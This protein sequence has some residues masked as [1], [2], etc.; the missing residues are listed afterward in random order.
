ML[1]LPTDRQRNAA[2]P[3]VRAEEPVH[4]SPEL[5][6]AVESLSR[7]AGTSVFIV[8]LAAFKALLC[9]YTGQEDIV[10]GT[11]AAD[12]SA[13]GNEL[14]L[15]QSADA[16]TIN[17]A[18]PSAMS[19]Q[20]LIDRVRRTT[21]DAFA[22]E[23]EPTLSEPAP[24]LGA[25]NATPLSV[26]F[27]FHADQ[28]T[29][30]KANSEVDAKWDLALSLRRSAPGLSGSLEYD[31]AL[32]DR[33]TVRRLVNHY[34]TL[35]EGATARPEERLSDLPLLGDAERRAVIDQSSG[36][37]SD[38]PR[39]KCVHELIQEQARRTPD[40]VAASSDQQLSYAELDRRSNKV[41]AYLRDLEIGPGS[42]V[43]ICFRHSAEELVA[44][45]GVLK[46]G[47]GYVPVDPDHPFFRRTFVLTDA[48]VKLVLTE[49]MLAGELVASGFQVVSLDA[50][51]SLIA[52]KDDAPVDAP[53]CAQDIAYVIYT[54]GSTGEPKGVAIAHQALVN[55]ISWANR[56]YLMGESAGFPLYS[57]GAFD[58]TVTSIYTPLI[59]G[60]TVVA[61]PEQRGKE[62][63]LSQI[64]AEP[65]VG[66]LKLTPSHLLLL[67]ELNNWKSAVKL[68]IVGGEALSTGL[69][70]EVSDN[71]GGQVEI[72]NEYGPT[73]ATVGCMIYRYDPA[74]DERPFVPIGRPA[75]N[76]YIYVLDACMNPAPDNVVGEL[77]IGGDGLAQGYVR[78]PALT[79][80]R[81][82][83]NPLSN[84]E[85][86]TSR[87]YRTG[88]LARRLSNGDIE[89]IGRCDEQVKFRGFR[90]ELSEVRAALNRHPEVRDSVVLIKRN[91][92]GT[93]VMVA[94]YAS[95]QEIAVERLR[96]FLETIIIRE[97]VPNFF[98]HLKRIPL[99]LNGKVNYKA[100]PAPEWNRG[101]ADVARV[102]PRN[103]IE[104]T[105]AEIWS[106]VL[107][108]PEGEIGVYDSFFTLGGHSLQALRMMTR[109][110]E[111]L[112]V[113][114]PLS[115]VYLS[116]NLS[117]LAEAVAEQQMVAIGNDAV[118]ALL[119]RIA[120]VQPQGD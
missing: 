28:E 86:R 78:R 19:F 95:R 90:V 51:W 92:T 18:C 62:W 7:Q 102:A 103:M 1:Q 47:A 81:F 59:S 87:L 101:E 16:V 15:R 44:L 4:I 33:S 6:T 98:V 41:A 11:S 112:R 52:S 29:G 23:T 45:L 74:T 46:S 85:A 100:L 39:S 91:Q 68:L 109:I 42:L 8:L 3:R 14:Q 53:V 75:D 82:L 77:Y 73:E 49:E 32:F 106:E 80:E 97:T 96:A 71:F 10:V 55:Y 119:E 61:Y 114:M 105:L 69:A 89:F 107:G 30:A 72:Y 118:Y 35:L 108:T 65:R 111:R 110:R 93:D 17:T 54:S 34:R 83:P 25:D 38:Y 76:V 120:G 43:G 56:V 22:R 12:H 64:L 63:V 99:T 50:D 94:Y 36:A 70:R 31:A 104:Q 24:K 66:V 9:R 20:G 48:Q 67:K 57:S 60:N 40:C 115:G 5:L 21:L 27:N 79:A 58:L 37:Q 84:E 2:Q 116:L 113:E 13:A 88:D 26:M 117:K